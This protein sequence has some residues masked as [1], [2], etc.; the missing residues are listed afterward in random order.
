MEI[1]TPNGIGKVVKGHVLDV[2]VKTIERQLQ[3]YD[4][5]LYIIWNPAKNSGNGIWEV[6]RRPNEKFAVYWSTV[7]ETDF[8]KLEYVELD[9][10]NHVL[11]VPRLDY[12]LPEK[13]KAMDA[14]VHK[15]YGKYLDDA[16]D[17]EERK[18]RKRENEEF[19][20]KLKQERQHIQ[21]FKE[22]VRSGYNP[23]YFLSQKFKG[24]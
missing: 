15:D 16:A 22:F 14:W 8:F 17:N 24:Y 21:A 2:N 1:L 9:L 20:Y 19:R 3:N 6:R 4:K 11:D 13:I 7:G 18:A 12:R 10:V 5:Q 23:A